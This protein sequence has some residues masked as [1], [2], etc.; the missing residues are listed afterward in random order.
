MTRAA[1][2]DAFW[3]WIPR[4]LDK[5]LRDSTRLSRSEVQAALADGRVRA[6]CRGEDVPPRVDRLVFGDDEIRLDGQ[7]V[8][9]LVEQHTCLLHKP[10]G[11]TATARDPEGRRDLSRWLAAMPRGCFP[12]GRLDRE[13]TGALLFTTDG[14][15]ANAVLHPDHRTPK[16]YDLRI[17]GHVC[18]D[19]PRLALLRSGVESSL[20]LLKAEEVQVVARSDDETAL[21]V[22]L[23]RG[24]NRQLRRMCYA[25]ELRLR[26]LHR[27]A[28]GPLSLDGLD[29][30]RWRRLTS[31]ECDRLW[32]DV[33]PRGSVRRHKLVALE[34]QAASARLEGAPMVRLERWLRGQEPVEEDHND[35]C[36]PM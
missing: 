23:C 15:L 28:I 5:F 25:A 6:R 3:R 20:G 33:S 1:P 34:R 27:C 13:T 31:E 17:A 35:S 18:D 16:I 36:P 21:R 11:V 26:H 7:I 14:D 9:P 2:D 19:D 22:T 30:G 24:K 32:R 4:R 29:R 10:K 12:V 8:R